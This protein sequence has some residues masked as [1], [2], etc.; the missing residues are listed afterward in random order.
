MHMIMFTLAIHAILSNIFL[1]CYIY[2]TTY[3]KKK[4][5]ISWMERFIKNNHVGCEFCTGIFSESE[6]LTLTL[7]G[8]IN[9]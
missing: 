1:F 8:V 3:N 2:Y 7:Q 6:L 5:L 4:K 9:V